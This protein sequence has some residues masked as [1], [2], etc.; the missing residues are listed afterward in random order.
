MPATIKI[1][2]D[3]NDKGYSIKIQHGLIERLGIEILRLNESVENE[4]LLTGNVYFYYDNKYVLINCKN[5]EIIN[6]CK[7]Y[8][9][10]LN[11]K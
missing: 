7:Y 10:L 8:C 5:E 1:K 11:G 6:P 9:L 2:L 3:E 4:I